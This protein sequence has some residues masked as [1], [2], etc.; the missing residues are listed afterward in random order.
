[1]RIAVVGP[2]ALGSLLSALFWEAGDEVWLV[3]RAPQQTR[4]IERHGLHL[5]RNG[6]KRTARV[7]CVTGLSPLL[8]PDWIVLCVKSYDTDEAARN[9]SRYCGPTTRV[10]TVQNGIGNREI[11]EQYIPNDQIVLASTAL[12]AHRDADGCIVHAGIGM[13]RTAP[14]YAR[15]APEAAR[16][17][18]Q[19]LNDRGLPAE[20]A[21]DPD[22]MLWTK[23]AVNAAINP[24]TAIHGIPNGALLRDHSLMETALAAGL[25]TLAVAAAQGIAI[26][27]EGFGDG[28]R[29]VCTHTARNTS[30][31]LQDVRAGKRTEIDQINGAVCSKGRELGIPTPAN[32]QLV[33]QVLGLKACSGAQL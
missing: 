22:A 30:S 21:R 2:G 3:A 4:E 11:L 23:L 7:H 9:I 18:A 26:E 24:L 29:S 10:V 16:M 14:S 32:D 5:I 8:A 12:G 1:M 31:M 19:N 13:T 17:F 15:V 25:E 28:L 27:H 33:T 20:C 6:K